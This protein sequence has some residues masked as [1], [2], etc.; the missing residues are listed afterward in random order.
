[1]FSPNWK[2]TQVQGESVSDLES[3]ALEGEKKIAL[4]MVLD[5][6]QTSTV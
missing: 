6:K 1:M 5:L 2:R 4:D 3:Y